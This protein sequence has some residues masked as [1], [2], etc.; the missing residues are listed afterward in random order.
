MSNLVE[1]TVTTRIQLRG[2]EL[3]GVAV[4]IGNI[5]QAAA[6]VHHLITLAL[7]PPRVGTLQIQPIYC[8]WHPWWSLGMTAH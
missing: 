3:I 2:D 5:T 1:I 6:I 8:I 7:S 4:I